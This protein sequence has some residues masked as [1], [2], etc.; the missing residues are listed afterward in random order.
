VIRRTLVIAGVIAAVAVAASPASAKPGEI[1]VGAGERIVK[2][3]PRNGESDVVADLSEVNP[4]AE[5]H[6]ADFG[7]D[8]RLYVVSESTQEVYRV[9]VKSGDVQLFASD[10]EFADPF[11]LA[12][13]PN[14]EI[15]VSDFGA[16]GP[17]E[18]TGALFGIKRSGAVRTISMGGELDRMNMLGIAPSGAM[19][20]PLIFPSELLRVDP[21]GEQS[22]VGTFDVPD[23]DYGHSAVVGPDGKVYVTLARTLHTFSPKSGDVALLSD[24][25]DF[26]FLFDL[27]VG[28]RG[29]LFVADQFAD[30]VVEVNRRTGAVSTLA[31]GGDLLGAVGL[32]VQPPRCG[33]KTATIVGTQ[34]SDKKL[35]GGP[36]KDV[37]AALGG[38]DR[39]NGKGGKD[40]ICG[41]KSGDKL[42]GG[43][44]KDKLVGGPGRDKL[45]GGPGKD[46]EQQ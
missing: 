25:P 2:V 13:A 35:K 37:I 40:I 21:N 33:G 5:A 11:G 30:A 29:E 34:K 18:D 9:N 39:V 16:F 6:G 27:D 43:G 41:G 38:K 31:S 46:K 10:P 44:G 32:A 1:Y 7:A 22:T 17:G 24:D 20:V 26:E 36:F 28:L 12:T 14:G 45:N 19:Y 42:K 4:S 3:N 23:D 15:V 8:G